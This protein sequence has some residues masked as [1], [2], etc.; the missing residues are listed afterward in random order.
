MHRR[1]RTAMGS[2]PT[3]MQASVLADTQQNQQPTAE[4]HM[5]EHLHLRSL[6]FA[7]D[8]SSEHRL[9][10]ARAIAS[11]APPNASDLASFW[12]IVGDTADAAFPIY[13]DVLPTGGTT[14][15][16]TAAFVLS[17]PRQSPLMVVREHKDPAIALRQFPLW[18]SDVGPG[19]CGETPPH[20]DPPCVRRRPTNASA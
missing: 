3:H 12:R 11:C 4:F 13:R 19:G 6:P 14:T 2:D 9:A 5:N 18:T 10:R 7:P 16:A 8:P 1:Q 15:A 20:S 17:A